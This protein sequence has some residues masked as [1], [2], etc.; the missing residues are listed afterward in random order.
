MLT[1]F[2]IAFSLTAMVACLH[3][4][5]ECTRRNRRYKL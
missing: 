1:D 2:L 3:D 5:W 4:V